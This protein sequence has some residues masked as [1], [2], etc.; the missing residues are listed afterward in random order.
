MHG[1][2]CLWVE[3]LCIP[4][5]K[6][7][8][9]LV[10]SCQKSSVSSLPLLSWLEFLGSLL[11]LHR[12]GGRSLSSTGIFLASMAVFLKSCS[13]WF[14][15]TKMSEVKLSKGPLLLRP[16]TSSWQRKMPLVLNEGQ[17]HPIPSQV[18]SPLGKQYPRSRGWRMPFYLFSF[19]FPTLKLLLACG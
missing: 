9:C 12:E 8:L 13:A 4:V 5:H 15:W 11:S 17:P 7:R 10:L 18:T 14:G 6:S 2:G 3:V 19:S 1:W 16:R